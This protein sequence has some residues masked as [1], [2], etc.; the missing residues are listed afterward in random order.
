MLLIRNPGAWFD[1]K[2]SRLKIL[3]AIEI[4]KRGTPGE[5]INKNFIIACSDNAVQILEIQ[6]EGKKK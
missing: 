4:E 1:Y 6:K 3:K 5:I 2:G